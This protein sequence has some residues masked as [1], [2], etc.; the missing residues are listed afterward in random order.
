MKQHLFQSGSTYI[1][2]EEPGWLKSA[3]LAVRGFFFLWLMQ[4]QLDGGSAMISP[5][6]RR[7]KPRAK[8]RINDKWNA[9]SQK[10]TADRGVL[11]DTQRWN[12]GFTLFYFIVFILLKYFD[13]WHLNKISFIK[14]YFSCPAISEEDTSYFV[15]FAV[16]VNR[17]VWGGGLFSNFK[18]DFSKVNTN[19]MDVILTQGF[20]YTYFLKAFGKLVMTNTCI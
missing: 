9:A 5:T 4:K 2:L 1:Q 12:L 16:F 15:V 7:W 17:F 20:K 14:K 11:Q 3:E 19:T 10:T 8:I 13:T 6:Q 18:P